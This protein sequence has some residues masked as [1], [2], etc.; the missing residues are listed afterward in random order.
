[1]VLHNED[2]TFHLR[3]ER[4]RGS[5][6]VAVVVG[7]AVVEDGGAGGVLRASVPQDRSI[8]LQDPG[9]TAFL[10]ALEAWRDVSTGERGPAQRSSR[11]SEAAAS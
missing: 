10:R 2:E 4:G 1:L 5:V 3:I 6:K 7:I 11:I 8:G 9:A